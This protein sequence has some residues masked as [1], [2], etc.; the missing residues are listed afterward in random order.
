MRGKGIQN[1]SRCVR[2]GDHPRVCGEKSMALGFCPSLRGS[3]PRV[4]GKVV[5]TLYTTGEKG[6]TPACAGKSVAVGH[7]APLARDHPRVCG[8]K[9][10]VARALSAAV[11]SP[12]RVRGKAFALNVC[13][14]S[15][16]ITPACAGKS[17]AQSW[18]LIAKWDHPRVCGEK[19]TFPTEV[20]TL[21]GSP[22][23]V[24][25]KDCLILR[26]TAHE[27]ITPAC[28][29]KRLKKA[30]KNKDF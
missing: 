17:M 25:G 23:R 30:L 8:E 7:W 4:R 27:G 10:C 12:P 2:T 16:G 1:S 13:I 20:F 9:P 26:H 19:K 18:R 22:P 29:G 11:G 21:L 14:N 28:A 15:P 3:P 5:V 24:R 6:I